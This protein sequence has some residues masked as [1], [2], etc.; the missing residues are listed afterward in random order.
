MDSS[1]AVL[2]RICDVGNQWANL[3]D[4][5]GVQGLAPYSAT[6]SICPCMEARLLCEHFFKTRLSP[7][8]IDKSMLHRCGTFV[9]NF[10]VLNKHQDC[11]W[12]WSLDIEA[13]NIH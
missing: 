3:A 9:C 11:R 12:F 5:A 1:F 8:T 7:T 13:M 10:K 6:G 2:Q 4:M